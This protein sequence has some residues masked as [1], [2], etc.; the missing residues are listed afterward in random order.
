MA[1]HKS[2]TYLLN[3]RGAEIAGL[4]NATPKPVLVLGAHSVDDNRPDE[5][6]ATHELRI[7]RTNKKPTWLNARIKAYVARF[8]CGSYSGSQFLH[9]VSHSV[10]AHTDA[11]QPRAD[12]SDYDDAGV[13]DLTNE[14]PVTLPCHQPRLQPPRSRSTVFM[15]L[16]QTTVI[17]LNAFS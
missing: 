10:G 11:L 14:G 8:D 13:V 1:L 4:D 16:V 9:A 3:Y 2:L 12:S 6:H 7:R 17:L 15:R 5:Q